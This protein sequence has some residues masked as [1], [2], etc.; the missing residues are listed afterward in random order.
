MTFYHNHASI[1]DKHAKDVE[2]IFLNVCKTED[3]WKQVTKVAVTTID[4][5]HQIL[6]SVLDEYSNLVN[7]EESD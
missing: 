4:L 1:D 2:K 7:E 3:D 6:M 5:T